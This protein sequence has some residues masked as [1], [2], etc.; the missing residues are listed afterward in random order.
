MSASNAIRFLQNSAGT[1]E[2]GLNLKIFWGSLVEAFRDG[3]ILFNDEYNVVAKKN[4]SGTNSAQFLMLADTPDSEDHT[5]GNE[6]LGQSY[7]VGDGTITVDGFVVSHHDVPR[8]QI[9]MSHFDI[10]S[11]LGAKMGK[12]LARN[13]DQKLFNLAINAA[14][15]AASTH[16]ATGLSIHNGGNRV[17]SVHASGVAS[18]FPVT[19][20]GAQAFRAKVAELAQAMDEDN[21]PEGGRHL[22][23][24]PYI[25][26]VCGQDTTIFSSDFTR[27][28]ANSLNSRT[29]GEM[30]GFMIHV[31]P[32]RIPSTTVSSYSKSKY[33]G[34]YLYTGSTGEPVAV[35]MCGAS[36]GSAAIGVAQ[37]QGIIPEM[38]DDARRSTVFM[39]A[40]ILMGAGI[41]HP[42]CAGSIEVDDS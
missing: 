29:I 13:Y 23:I 40:S 37:V 14:R 2:N 5:P 15:T 30:E 25:R 10:V 38:V 31:A 12:R 36:D 28:P 41:L 24:T 1:D 33:N 7:A 11:A 20:A 34:D 6:L 18:A 26:R 42:W 8:D 4:I 17:E 9:L 19:Q 16:T 21:V 3:S 22:F 39:K 35:A 27:N 32:N